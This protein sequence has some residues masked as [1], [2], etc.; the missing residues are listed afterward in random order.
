MSGELTRLREGQRVV[1]RGE[2]ADRNRVLPLIYFEPFVHQQPGWRPPLEWAEEGAP[3]FLLCQ[4]ERPEAVWLASVEEEGTAWLRLFAVSRDLAPEEAWEALWPHGEAAL[5]QRGVRSLY[6]LSLHPWLE[7]LVQQFGFRQVSSV[8]NMAWPRQPLPPRRDIAPLVLRS[9]QPEDIP[10]ALAVDRA[11]FS[12]PWRMGAR[13]MERVYQ[14][15]ALA[16]VVTDAQGVVGYQISTTGPGGGH[17]ARLAVHPRAQ[18]RNVGFALVHDALTTLTAQ[19]AEWVTVNT[20]TENEAAIRLYRRFGFH[21]LPE[22]SPVY[23]LD[24]ASEAL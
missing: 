12:P 17:L 11:A 3:F 6:V 16:R 19:G 8:R 4:D 24:L 5:R 7:R 20:W 15:A 10:A 9:M 2:A 1:R 13:D 14:E 22:A 21:F 23:R 18:G